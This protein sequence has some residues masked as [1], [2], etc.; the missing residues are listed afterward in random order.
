MTATYQQHGLKFMYPENW[1]LNEAETDALP[2]IVHL[3]APDGAAMWEVH[4]HD[5]DADA[6]EILDAAMKTLRE[7]YADLEVSSSSSEF[8]GD[9]TLAYEG[10]FFCLDFL[11]RIKLQTIATPDHL[12]VFWYQAEDRHFEEVEMVF[13]AITTSLR[14]SLPNGI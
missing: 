8:D 10:L 6:T 11:I 4:L 2:Q 13:R 3:D 9:E 1:T 14:Q 7:T 12:L 5:A